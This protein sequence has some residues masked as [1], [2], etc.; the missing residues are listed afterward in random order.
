MYSRRSLPVRPCLPDKSPF[1]YLLLLHA[2][3]LSSL[4]IVPVECTYI[5]TWHHHK[6]ILTTTCVVVQFVAFLSMN[7]VTLGEWNS[8][9]LNSLHG[10]SLCSRQPFSFFL[11]SLRFLTPFKVIFFFTF[12]FFSFLFF[13]THSN[14]SVHFNDPMIDGSKGK[15]ANLSE[16]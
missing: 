9:I 10:F 2:N 11:A 8:S 5:I 15:A 12:P 13:W 3:F 14:V 1:S 7:Y 4:R 6:H 16:S